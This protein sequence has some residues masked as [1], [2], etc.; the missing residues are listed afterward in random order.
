MGHGS[1]W[2]HRSSA[3]TSQQEFGRDR[4]TALAD[5]TAGNRYSTKS[6]A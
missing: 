4:E 3:E 5:L 1:Y 6:A 2:R